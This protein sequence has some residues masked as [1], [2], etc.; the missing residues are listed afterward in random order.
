MIAASIPTEAL[1]DVLLAHRQSK[2]ANAMYPAE[3]VRR[4]PSIKAVSVH[5]GVVETDLLTSLP[6][7]RRRLIYGI[8]KLQGI[9][10]LKENEGCLNQL[11]A[12][13]GAR[14]DELVNG[15]FYSK[16]Y[17]TSFSL[18]HLLCVVRLKQ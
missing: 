15:A 7:F 12:A 17:F 11:W 5:P 13:A 18:L 14:R 6:P 4:Y 8:V 16:L 2:L 1:S 3:L 9:K 10:I